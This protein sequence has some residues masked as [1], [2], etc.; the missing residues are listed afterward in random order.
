M[1]LSVIILNIWTIMSNS[2][3][4]L[5]KRNEN[6]FFQNSFFEPKQL[7]QKAVYQ[8]PINCLTWSKQLKSSQTTLFVQKTIVTKHPLYQ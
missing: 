7:F 2:Q 3:K 8:T 4:A 1:A 5:F 6:S